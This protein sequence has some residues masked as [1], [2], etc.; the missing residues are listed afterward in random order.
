MRSEMAWSELTV[1]KARAVV[2]SL[3]LGL[4]GC[5]TQFGHR[6]DGQGMTRLTPVA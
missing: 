3:V 4:T 5:A 1:C 6:F 2:A